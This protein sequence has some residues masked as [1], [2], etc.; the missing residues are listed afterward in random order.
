MRE[1]KKGDEIGLLLPTQGGRSRRGKNNI[2]N[3]AIMLNYDE[4]IM[5]RN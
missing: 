4:F 1:G 5:Y 2:E 3:L